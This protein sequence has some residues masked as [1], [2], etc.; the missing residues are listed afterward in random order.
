MRGKGVQGNGLPGK[1]L[2]MNGDKDTGTELKT[3][4]AFLS[5]PIN[6]ANL[7]TVPIILWLHLHSKKYLDIVIEIQEF[8][9]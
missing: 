1:G 2:Q 5:P 6:K 4:K 8:L 3:I 9:L 7:V